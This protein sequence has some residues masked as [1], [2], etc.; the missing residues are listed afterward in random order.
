MTPGLIVFLFPVRIR[1]R[2]PAAQES[3]SHLP[4][5][6]LLRP[7]MP[8]SRCARRTP[9]VLFSP[10]RNTHPMSPTVLSSWLRLQRS[11]APRR[12]QTKSPSCLRMSTPRGDNS[13]TNPTFTLRSGRTRRIASNRHHFRPRLRCRSL[14]FQGA[15]IMPELP[16]PSYPIR[17]MMMTT[18]RQLSTW[19]GSRSI[20]TDDWRVSN[21]GSRSGPFH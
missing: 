16:S 3:G 10:P 15:A 20:D 6:K 7:C 1:T 4:S 13:E 18:H 11:I 2:A 9:R 17:W 14:K 5:A 21:N 19:R 12:A 8:H